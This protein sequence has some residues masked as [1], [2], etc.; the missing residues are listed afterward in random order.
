MEGLALED[1]GLIK[2][3]RALELLKALC[4][5]TDKLVFL[6]ARAIEVIDL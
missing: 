5:L 6:G 1:M 3:F 2:R 4:K